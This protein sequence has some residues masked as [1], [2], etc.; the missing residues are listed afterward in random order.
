MCAGGSPYRLPCDA[1]E[2]EADCA[3]SL[4]R[5]VNISARLCAALCLSR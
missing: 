2:E 5:F 3:L 4:R 1:K